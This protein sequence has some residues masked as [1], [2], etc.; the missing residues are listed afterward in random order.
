MTINERI[1][2]FTK[3]GNYVSAIDEDALESLI[4]RAKMH[5]AWFTNDNIRTGI[6]GLATYLEEDRLRR[7]TS[8]Y[9]LINVSSKTVAIVMAG[10]VPFVGFHDLLS[11]L[12]SGHSAQVKLSSKDSILIPHLTSKLIEL[13]PR[14]SPNITYVEQLKDFDAVIATGSDNSARYFDYYF[15]KYPHIIRKNRTSCA[16]LSGNETTDELN[17]LGGDIFTHFGLGCRNVS[18]IFVPEGYSFNRFFE[19]IESYQ[20]IIHH[21]KYHNNYDYQMS[22]MLVN[23]TKYLDNGFLMVTENEKMV[24]PIAVVYYETYNSIDALKM[25]LSSVKDK[26]QCIVGKVTPATVS[27][28]QTQYPEL[29]DYADQIDTLRFLSELR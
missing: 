14:F 7:W 22:I 12:I 19:S 2:A 3:L 20:P 11:V 27:F 4:D 8:A 24:S 17:T 16:I 21:H 26:I 18:K 6:R 25:K 10:N 13:E 9:N 15:A 1:Q 28:G 29:W 23:G 5:N